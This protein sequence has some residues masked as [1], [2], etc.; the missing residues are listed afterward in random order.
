MEMF[1]RIVCP[2]D[3]SDASFGALQAAQDLARH[4]AGELIVVHVVEPIP[5]VPVDTDGS[6][7]FDVFRYEDEL[8]SAAEK[9]LLETLKQR[10]SG[11]VTARP[12]VAGGVPWEEIVR[13]AT[14]EKADLLVI[15]THG[16]SGW[17]HLLFGSVTERVIRV[18]PCPVLVIRSPKQVDPTTERGPQD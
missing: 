12:L 5:P 9:L 11:E 7:R 13:I 18:A 3:F 8:M 17:K 6:I 1:R 15:A 2:T 4:F 16:R 10:L 14:E